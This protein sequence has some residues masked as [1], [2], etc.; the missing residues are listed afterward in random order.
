M[1]DLT[2]RPG[3]VVAVDEIPDCDYCGQCEADWDVPTV[4]GPWANLC[5]RCA[6]TIARHPGKTGVGIGQRLVLREEAGT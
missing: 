3:H 6:F 2:P 5:D 4:Y 1:E